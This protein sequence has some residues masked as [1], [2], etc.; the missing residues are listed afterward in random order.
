MDCQSVDLFSLSYSRA[1]RQPLV[2]YLPQSV[3]S[4][5]ADTARRAGET[6]CTY[7]LQHQSYSL[8][9]LYT[10]RDIYRRMFQYTGNNTGGD[11]NSGALAC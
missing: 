7:M 11:K 2:F 1:L 4:K 9:R 10:F 5:P 3:I 6:G 8:S